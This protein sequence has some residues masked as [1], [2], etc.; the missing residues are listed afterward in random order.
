MFRSHLSACSSP[1]SYPPGKK[2]RAYSVEP[3]VFPIVSSELAESLGLGLATAARSY[4]GVM[5]GTIGTNHTCTYFAVFGLKFQ[6]SVF[7]HQFGFAT[8]MLIAR[9]HAIIQRNNTTET[10]IPTQPFHIHAAMHQFSQKLMHSRTHISTHSHTFR[11]MRF[12]FAF[13]FA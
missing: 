2:K 10:H 4:G 3:A 13:G 12:F 5:Q 11:V 8:T 7:N 6:C 1:P 9:A